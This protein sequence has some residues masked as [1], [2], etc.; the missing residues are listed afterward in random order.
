LRKEKLLAIKNIVSTLF[1]AEAHYNPNLIKKELL[2]VFRREG[3][4]EGKREAERKSRREIARKMISKGFEMAL[5]AEVT[6]LSESEL[7]K[8]S[9]ATKVQ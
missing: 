1:L 9:H 7:R 3:K 6:G 4:R 8:L 5:I 2:E